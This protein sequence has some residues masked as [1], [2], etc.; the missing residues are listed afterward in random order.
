MPHSVALPILHGPAPAPLP[1]SHLS[2]PLLLSITVPTSER[3]PSFD[4]SMHVY[5]LPVER[6]VVVNYWLWIKWQTLML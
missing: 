4:V 3:L 6:G 2:R 5:S 1:L